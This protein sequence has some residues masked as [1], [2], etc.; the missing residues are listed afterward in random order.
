MRVK[1]LSTRL[2]NRVDILSICLNDCLTG[3]PVRFHSR[4]DNFTLMAGGVHVVGAYRRV[5]V[6][7]DC[8][9]P[10]CNKR[11]DCQAELKV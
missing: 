6:P 11:Q 3:L 2:D 5:L 1:N 4:V 9:A 7:E 8:Q 10:G